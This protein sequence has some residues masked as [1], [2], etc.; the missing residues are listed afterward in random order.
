MYRPIG[1]LAMGA[2]A[3]VGATAQAQGTSNGVACPV[4][5]ISGMTLDEEFGPGTQA[6][7]TCNQK[8]HNVKLLVQINQAP[9]YALGN[10]RSI[11]NDYEVTYG[12]KAGRDYEI[13]AIVYGAGGPTVI[14]D[15][16]NS[17]PNP[18]ESQVSDLI[19]RGVK[20][21]IAQTTARAYILNGRLTAGH[22]TEQLIPGVGY[23]T[24]GISATADFESRG[25][26]YVQP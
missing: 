5:L 10:L 4:G 23:V 25:F 20:F 17:Y 3:L 1:W 21:L 9:P 14:Q 26:Q 16:V 7:T 13:V 2:L 6:L 11:I 15:G 24:A 19:N 18:Y 22:A 8:R 12:M